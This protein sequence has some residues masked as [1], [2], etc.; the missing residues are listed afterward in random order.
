[1]S[2]TSTTA[3]Q[4]HLLKDSNT[5]SDNT[6]A[7][8]TL[9]KEVDCPPAAEETRL[10]HTCISTEYENCKVFDDC[11]V[12]RLEELKKQFDVI[13]GLS[14]YESVDVTK[15]R[16]AIDAVTAFAEE[17]K[18]KFED[19]SPPLVCGQYIEPCTDPWPSHQYHGGGLWNACLGGKLQ[20]ELRTHL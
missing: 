13:E 19:V 16:Q 14:W 6:T 10:T 5:I 1:M 4:E 20:E 18:T 9:I 17:C 11:Q 2:T 8:F 12:E 7:E 3:N 15:R